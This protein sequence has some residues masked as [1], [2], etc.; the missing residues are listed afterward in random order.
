MNNYVIKENEVVYVDYNDRE[1]LLDGVDLATFEVLDDKTLSESDLEELRKKYNNYAL[2]KTRWA[3]KDK[4]SV[5]AQELKIQG[6]DPETFEFYLG[7]QCDW[8]QDKNGGYCFYSYG[9]NRIKP[10]TLTGFLQF[11]KNDRLGGYMRMYAHDD[12]YVYYY[13]RR[14]RG[15]TSNDCRYLIQEDVDIITNTLTGEKYEDL[16]CVVSNN[17]VFYYGKV[18]KDADGATA[19]GF[20]IDEPGQPSLYVII[21]KNTIYYEGKPFTPFVN[22]YLYKRIPPVLFELQKSLKQL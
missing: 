22:P 12:K 19:M 20:S 18:L 8:G 7:G 21:D 15:A 10:I 9:K 4:N 1:L 17:I 11:F 6:A 14:C 16:D 2:G 5:W 13:G 3:A